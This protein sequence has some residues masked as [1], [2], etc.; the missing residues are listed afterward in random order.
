MCE[1]HLYLFHKLTF[2]ILESFVVFKEG[3]SAKFFVCQFHKIFKSGLEN[4]HVENFVA[5]IKK[6]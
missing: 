6:E 5:E 3:D 4:Q 1:E 2:G